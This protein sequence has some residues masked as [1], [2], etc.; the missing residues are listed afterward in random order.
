MIPKHESRQ[1]GDA[2]S[3]GLFVLAASNWFNRGKELVQVTQQAVPK[4]IENQPNAESHDGMTRLER[5][6]RRIRW[7]DIAGAVTCVLAF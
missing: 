3:L 6:G 4:P 7:L 5:L 1:G 2:K